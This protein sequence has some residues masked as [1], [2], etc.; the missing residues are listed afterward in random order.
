MRRGRISICDLINW[1]WGGPL[2]AAPAGRPGAELAATPT[3]TAL[4]GV[5]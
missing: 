1:G 3:P 2:V 4:G 5:D